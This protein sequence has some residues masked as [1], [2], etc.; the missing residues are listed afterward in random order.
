M[1]TLSKTREDIKVSKVC[2]NIERRRIVL[3]AAIVLTERGDYVTHRSLSEEIGVGYQ[4]IYKLFLSD[5]WLLSVI[6]LKSE[7]MAKARSRLLKTKRHLEFKNKI[8]TISSI[9]SELH[10]RDNSKLN[11]QFE[12]D[13]TLKVELGLTESPLVGHPRVF[14]A[15]RLVV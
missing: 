7:N 6:P 15:R 12:K 3:A 1:N 8:V 14:P 5:S 4:Y 2:K 11:R 10:M 13:T 9:C